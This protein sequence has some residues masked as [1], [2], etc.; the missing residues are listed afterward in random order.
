MQND[1]TM[2]EVTTKAK[3]THMMI[4]RWFESDEDGVIMVGALD[5]EDVLIGGGGVWAKTAW[6]AGSFQVDG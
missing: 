1:K 6:R 4:M 3:K 2:S 5:G